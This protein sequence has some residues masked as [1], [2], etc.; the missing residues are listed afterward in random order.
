MILVK[1]RNVFFF[2]YDMPHKKIC[3]KPLIYLEFAKL[4]KIQG[5][6]ELEVEICEDGLVDGMRAVKSVVSG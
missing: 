6:V 2:H 5:T 3:D 4:A 1:L